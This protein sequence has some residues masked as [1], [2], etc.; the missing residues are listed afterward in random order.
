[1][2]AVIDAG[3]TFSSVFAGGR[4]F[5]SAVFARERWT[6]SA[7]EWDWSLLVTLPL[8]I[9]LLLYVAGVVRVWR[10]AGAGR[11]ISRWSV[12]SFAAG[13]LTLAVALV[14]P[15]AWLSEILFSV[16]MTQ[17]TLLMLVAAPLLTFGHPLLAWMW[18]LDAATRDRVVG[19]VRGPR[20][21]GI[22]QRLT[23]PL[24]VFLIQAAALW[25]W[26]IPSWYQAALRHDGVHAL[27][28]LCLVLAGSL[29]WWA[30]VHG[31]YGRGGYGLAVLYVFLTAVHS[32]G[33]GALL[34]MSPTVWYPD[35]AAAATAW[36]VD[37][38]ADQQ[39]AGLLMWIP[40]GVIFIVF[41]LA[42]MA[43]WLGET[44]RRV[45]FSLAD[46]ASRLVPAL[47]LVCCAAFATACDSGKAA[48]SEA[49]TLTG[50][51]VERGK[52]AIGKYGCGSC[53]TIPGLTGAQ[54]TVGPPLTSIAVRGYLAGHLPNSPDNMMKWIQ[55]PQKI[56]PQVVMPEMGVTD[57]DA[58]DITAY[59]YTLR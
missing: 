45:R 42:L 36:H 9:T 54:A 22:W 7:R 15:V 3:L 53:H 2:H 18:A 59:L 43:A 57:Q 41:G 32:G 12:V 49:E 21:R 25:M 27:E 35:Y 58:R 55:H 34:A 33:L 14:S 5:R 16:H 26:H 1:M 48:A 39:L 4:T 11:G 46:N 40:A 6:T 19:S 52:S 10:R 23:A 24:V 38:L 56:D 17:H 44:E 28:H 37:A 29:F 20:V 30:M 50:G 47:L 8:A 31:R 51:S 13:W